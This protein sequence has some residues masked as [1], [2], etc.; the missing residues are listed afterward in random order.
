MEMA[1]TEKIFM[2]LLIGLVGGQKRNQINAD[3]MVKFV[4]ITVR[5]RV[6]KT[7][8]V[9]ELKDTFPQIAIVHLFLLYFFHQKI[10]R[11]ERVKFGDLSCDLLQH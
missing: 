11:T 2:S 1:F 3:D 9:Q 7:E 8:G 4:A 5:C 10:I 6:L